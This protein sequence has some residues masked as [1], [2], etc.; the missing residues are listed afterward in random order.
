MTLITANPLTRP[1][2]LEM[3]KKSACGSSGDAGCTRISRTTFIGHHGCYRKRLRLVPS[4]GLHAPEFILER[5]SDDHK[6]SAGLRRMLDE[7][8]SLCDVVKR[9][10]LRDVKA[11]P[12]GFESAI[13]VL[14]GFT[15]RLGRSIITADEKQSGVDKHQLPNRD[16][17]AGSIRGVGCDRTALRKHFNVSLDVGSESYFDDVIDA[18]GSHLTD[19]FRK[20]CVCQEDVVRTGARSNVLVAFGTACGDHTRS[21]PMRKLNGTSSDCSS[22]TL[23]E[24]CSAFDGTRDMNRTMGGDAGNTE[25][26]SLF[27][28]HPVAQ[29]NRLLH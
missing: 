9:E 29:R 21:Y 10:P 14:S 4:C 23:H 13:D 3:L 15:L 7:L 1:A 2:Y 27:Y 11:L 28:G 6:H 19:A 18:I 22:A 24:D 16:F 17:R 26:G 25:T 20:S 5:G 12:A 8:V